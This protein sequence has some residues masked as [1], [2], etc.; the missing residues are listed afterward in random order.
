[1]ITNLK[2]SICNIYHQSTP[3]FYV[4]RQS[5]WQTKSMDNSG[6][7]G[8]EWG[9]VPGL[10][11]HPFLLKFFFFNKDH[12]WPFWGPRPPT[13]SWVKKV[14]TW[15]THIPFQNFLDPPLGNI[16]EWP[17]HTN[18]TQKCTMLWNSSDMYWIFICVWTKEN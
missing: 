11:T 14:Q 3:A 12:F 9:R 18:V 4:G 2:L 1:M 17:K 16:G 13:L 15:V 10:Q 5:Y 6:R 8:G 7:S